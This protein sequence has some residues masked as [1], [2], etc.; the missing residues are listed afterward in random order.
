MT[1]KITISCI[2]FLLIISLIPSIISAAR[3]EFTYEY[4][5][6]KIGKITDPD[7]DYGVYYFPVA[8]ILKAIDPDIQ[9]TYLGY[10]G[11]YDTSHIIFRNECYE[12]KYGT[13]VTIYDKEC[14]T[15]KGKINTSRS[16][17]LLDDKKV[18][19]PAFIF[20]DILGEG[21]TVSLYTNR[22][23]IRTKEHNENVIKNNKSIILK[24]NDP[25]MYVNEEVKEFDPEQGSTPVVREGRT[26]LPIANVIVEFGGNVKW[27]GKEQKVTVALDGSTVELWIGKKKATVNGV[28]ETLDV[29]PSV[30]GGRTMIPLRFVSDNLGIQL[31]WDKDNQVIA[32]YRGDFDSLPKSYSSYF[33]YKTNETN[34]SSKQETKKDQNS[35]IK[36]NNTD[37]L[38]D[39]GKLV[40]IGDIV[41]AGGM[42]SGMVKDING[43]KILVYWDSKSMFVPKGDEDFWALVVGI[44]YK[45]SQW[46]EA[47]EV[48][49]ESSGY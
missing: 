5:G 20:E 30:I 18:F 34:G 31:V 6:K 27:D 13:K 48:T 46:I 45:S 38:D 37:P 28:E 17:R 33:I 9:E 44:K 49:I 25:W 19:M 14:T 41:S 22:I 4:N 23:I 36:Y 10:D 29:P 8:E 47:K 11:S 40:R 12:F 42:F 1:K 32:L 26:L 21:T 16:F 15:E 43:T 7:L 39:N 24:V 35:G 3:V 2:A